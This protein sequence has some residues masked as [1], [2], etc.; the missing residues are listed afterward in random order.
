MCICVSECKDSVSTG[1]YTSLPT[2][3][4]DYIAVTSREVVFSTVET[5]QVVKVTIEQDAVAEEAEFFT[6]TLSA[7][8]GESLVQI[9]AQSQATATIIDDDGPFCLAT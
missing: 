5:V 2:A 3:S 7:A 1:M 6:A 8:P 9:G 4:G